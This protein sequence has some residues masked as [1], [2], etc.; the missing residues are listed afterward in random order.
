MKIL[1]LLFSILVFPLKEVVDVQL[2]IPTHQHD[3]FANYTNDNFSQAISSSGPQETAHIKT[4][5]TLIR[6]I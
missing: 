5:I 4:P 6:S 2:F 1:V 3:I